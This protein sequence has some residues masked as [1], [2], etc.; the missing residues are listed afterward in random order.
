MFYTFIDI[1][2]YHLRVNSFTQNDDE[3][4]S[5][6]AYL[7]G[8]AR[9]RPSRR[10]LRC[11]SSHTHTP[12]MHPGDA[13]RAQRRRYIRV[14]D[15]DIGMGEQ[16]VSLM[17]QDS[18]PSDAPQGERIG[19][20]GV[21][22]PA[23]AAPH[24]RQVCTLLWKWCSSSIW[25]VQLAGADVFFKFNFSLNF[26]FRNYKQCMPLISYSQLHY[27]FISLSSDTIL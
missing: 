12:H 9:T 6:S 16:W 10:S 3:N 2:P 26:L 20:L 5:G 21:T 4:V 14:V 8:S 24:P 7:M 27:I 11:S 25:I 1:F 19:V 23:R 17:Q 18:S 15:F 22:S 13:R